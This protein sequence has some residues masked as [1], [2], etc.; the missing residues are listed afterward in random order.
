[1]EGETETEMTETQR[2]TR[3]ESERHR[4]TKILSLHLRPE[5]QSVSLGQNQ[6]LDRSVAPLEMLGDY[7][8]SAFSSS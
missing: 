6:G 8:V 1:M 2:E 7:P 5:I 4:E 3:T